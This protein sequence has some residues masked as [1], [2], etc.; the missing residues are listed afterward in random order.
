[1]ANAAGRT[2]IIHERRAAIHSALH[3]ARPGDV[4]LLAGKGHEQTIERNGQVEAWDE[5]GVVR[6]ALAT[7]GYP[8]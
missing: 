8:R 5:V 6:E 4:V 7:L 1:V 2:Q 3:E